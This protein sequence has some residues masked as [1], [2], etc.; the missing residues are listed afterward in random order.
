MRFF[1][2][3]AKFVSPESE[4]QDGGLLT[5]ARE[6]LEQGAQHLLAAPWYVA[7]CAT[8]LLLYSFNGRP[9]LGTNSLFRLVAYE[10]YTHSST[11]TYI[12]QQD[13]W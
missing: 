10:S 4:R 5:L 2:S 6:E 11:G 8:M 9:N 13:D 3:P 12:R 1:L 7:V